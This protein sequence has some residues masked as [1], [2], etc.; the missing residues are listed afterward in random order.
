M[1]ATRVGI[2]GLQHESNTFSPV[3]TGLEDFEVHAGPAVL[4]RWGGSHH[5]VAGFLR[6]LDDLGVEAVPLLVASATPS[7]RIRDDALADIVGRMLEAVERAGP[8][9]GLLAAAHGAAV[10]EGLE[11][12]D[13]HWLGL[14]RARLGRTPIVC[15]VD[16]HANLSPDMVR[17]CEAVIAYRSNPH[18][19]TFD[20]GV[21]AAHLLVRTLRGEVRPATAAAFPPVAINILAQDTGSWPCRPMYELAEEMRGREGV[22]AVSICLGFPYADVA[23][24]GAAFV[25]VTDGRPDLARRLCDELAAHLIDRRADFVPRFLEAEEAVELAARSEGPV[26]LLDTGDNVGGGSAG[27]GT[28]IAHIVARRGGPR[29]FVSLH[30]PESVARALEAGVGARVRLRVGGKTDDLHGPP[31]DV[32]GEVLRRHHGR[33]TETAVRHGGHTEFDMGATVVV[34]TE[35]GLTLQ[36]TSRRI[37]PFS[38]NQLLCCGVDPRE[39]HI[40]VAK[41]VHAPVPAYAPVCRTIIRATTPG[42]TT[43][44]LSR[45]P[46]R[47][48][49]RPLF[50]FEELAARP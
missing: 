45:L 29:T 21:E 17:A 39:F 10:G 27:D 28:A 20:R 43:P 8:L 48:R 46:F 9:H 16:A 32:E 23:K 18:L 31:L 25:V 26:C 47:R 40:L 7:G 34:A 41:G 22:L 4:E 49:R 44:D 6:G 13:A 37:V 24:M 36:L 12:A 3:P 19:D 2:V 1:T 42:S 30:D 11:D 33:F 5:E 14:L 15:T 50:P 35:V 38:L